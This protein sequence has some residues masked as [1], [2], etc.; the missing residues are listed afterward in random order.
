MLRRV[1]TDFCPRC[2]HSVWRRY[3]ALGE[4]RIGQGNEHLRDGR[5]G[6]QGG[7]VVRCAICAKDTVVTIRMRIAGEEVTFRRCSGCERNEWVAGA[8]EQSLDDIL[9]LVRVSR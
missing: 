3:P 1:A 2:R 5:L 8:G 4:R 6:E 7:W 9:D